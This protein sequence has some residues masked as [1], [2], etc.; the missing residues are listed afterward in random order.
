MWG[1]FE[2]RCAW[3]RVN[4][5]VYQT[6]QTKRKVI[7]Y[8]DV[9]LNGII[10]TVPV[11]WNFTIK[12]SPRSV[13]NLLC[14]FLMFSH[15]L[16]HHCLCIFFLM[17]YS[18]TG[19]NLITFHCSKVDKSHLKFTSKINKLYSILTFDLMSNPFLHRLVDHCHCI[20]FLVSYS[21]SG[22]NMVTFHSI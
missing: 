21:I 3:T 13:G 11:C 8:S 16:A 4:R 9:L 18:I 20:F 12:H 19:L 5:I 2:F 22:T 14:L 17:P 10:P 15:M 7:V 6:N 1:L